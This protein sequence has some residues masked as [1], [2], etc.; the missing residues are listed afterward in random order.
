M[1]CWQGSLGPVAFEEEHLV[2]HLTSKQFCTGSLKLNRSYN[3]TGKDCHT[4][5]RISLEKGRV[6]KK[7][8]FLLT[9]SQTLRQWWLMALR[10]EFCYTDGRVL[11]ALVRELQLTSLFIQLPCVLQIMRSH[12]LVNRSKQMSAPAINSNTTAEQH[13]HAHSEGSMLP[14]LTSEIFW[15]CLQQTP[16][17]EQIK[18]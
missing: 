9:F 16:G 13:S 7:I 14:S 1:H 12:K 10:K 6:R 11:L 8:L 17:N 15:S 3:W 5:D 4:Y 18:L 2:N